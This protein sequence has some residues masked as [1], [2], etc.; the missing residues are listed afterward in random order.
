MPNTDATGE[1]IVFGVFRFIGS[2]FSCSITISIII[3]LHA[4]TTVRIIYRIFLDEVKNE[5]YRDEKPMGNDNCETVL[6][7]SADLLTRN[8]LP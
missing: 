6:N 2:G 4:H 1:Y 8:M 7:C 5:Y 3:L